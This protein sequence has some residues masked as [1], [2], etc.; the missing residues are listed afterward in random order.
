MDMI[1]NVLRQTNRDQAN[2]ILATKVK[3]ILKNLETNKGDKNQV[4]TMSCTE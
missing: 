4:P 1:I 2:L 3:Q